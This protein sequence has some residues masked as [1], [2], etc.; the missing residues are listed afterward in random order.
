MKPLILPTLVNK[1][2]QSAPTELGRIEWLYNSTDYS[3][4]TNAPSWSDLTAAGSLTGANVIGIWT[5]GSNDSSGANTGLCYYYAAS[6]IVSADEIGYVRYNTGR[7]VTIPKSSL[8]PGTSTTIPTPGAID[9]TNT[10]TQ[11]VDIDPINSRIFKCLEATQ[12]VKVMD[13]TGATIE[14]FSVAGDGA[15]TS[16]PNTLCYDYVRDEL[17]VTYRSRINIWKKIS[18]TWTKIGILPF[19]SSEGN[20]PNYID[21]RFIANRELTN[22]VFTRISEQDRNGWFNRIYALPGNAAA[23]N[24]GIIYD[25]RDNT[26]WF[27][28]DQHFH[29]GITNGNR[30]YHLDPNKV[31][32]KKLYFPGMIR[33]NKFKIP[34]NSTIVGDYNNQRIKGYDFSS[35]PVID[36]DAYTD[37][38]TLANFTS[39]NSAY[40]VEFRGSNTAPTTSSESAGHLNFYDANSSNDGW[41]S[42]TPGA[43]S[44]SVPALRY[45][46][47]RIRSRTFVATDAWEPSDLGTKLKLLF[48]MAPGEDGMWYDSDNSDRVDRVINKYNPTNSLRYNPSSGQTSIPTFSLSNGYAS[49]TNLQYWTLANPASILSDTQGEICFIGRSGGGVSTNQ[50]VAF[51][52]TNPSSNNGVIRFGHYRSTTDTFLD[53][54]HMT[55]IDGAGTTSRIG[56]VDTDHSTFKMVNINSN[57]STNAAYL[58]KVSQTLTNSGGTNTGKWLATASGASVVDVGVWRTLSGGTNPAVCDFKFLMYC[59]EPLTTQERSDL[60]DW[61]VAQGIL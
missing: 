61:L 3:Y 56:F 43:W 7:F 30:L 28:S 10:G 23:D 40:D 1:Q 14:T 53:A 24:E 42:T 29:G 52:G 50:L 46:Q 33:Y 31:F 45:V 11:G 26:V 44:S 16:E 51:A 19:T 22:G 60:Y 59:S 18:S 34:S 12:E 41:G 21:D 38:Q 15:I 48:V 9:F 47:F 55:I 35:S 49:K 2:N 8:T 25:P 32:Q 36:F 20:Y 6:G 37:Q 58:N 4:L 57:G 39:S 17:Y 5:V 54:F 27:N 13:M